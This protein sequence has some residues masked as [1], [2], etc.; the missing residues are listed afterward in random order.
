MNLEGHKTKHLSFVFVLL[1]LA[2]LYRIITRLY[3]FGFVCVGSC[4]Q[5]LA[6][7]F[8]LENI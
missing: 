7:K 3:L 6:F 1:Y 8:H 5:M 2:V 4:F